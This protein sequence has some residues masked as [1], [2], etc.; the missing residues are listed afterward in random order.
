MA[1]V[2]VGMTVVVDEGFGDDEGCG[3]GT[4]IQQSG[5][6]CVSWFCAGAVVGLTSIAADAFGGYAGR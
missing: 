3:V 5:L 2:L 1:K 6:F 4:A